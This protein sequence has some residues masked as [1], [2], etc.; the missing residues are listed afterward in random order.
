MQAQFIK[1]AAIMLTACATFLP[2]LIAEARIQNNAATLP[3]GL[4]GAAVV[5]IEDIAGNQ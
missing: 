4:N 5:F 3:S 1:T 2:G